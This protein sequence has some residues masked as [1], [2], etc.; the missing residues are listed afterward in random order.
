MDN[1]EAMFILKP[2]LSEEDRKTLFNQLGEVV[3]KFNG[4]VSQ[5]SIWS[6][7]KKLFF[8]LKRYLEGLYYLINFNA[9]PQ[10]L[11]EI[12]HAYGLNENILRVLITKLES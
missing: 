8:P 7:K 5:A 2:D 4:K 3:A 1:Y 12:R 9:A 6:E 11:A 10:A